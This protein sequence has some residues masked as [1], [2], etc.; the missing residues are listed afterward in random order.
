MNNPAPL[1]AIGA[2][3]GKKREDKFRGFGGWRNAA[4]MAGATLAAAAILNNWRA[5]RA[6][7]RNPPMGRF[8]L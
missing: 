4:A 2:T 7:Q 6:E 8:L 1:P 3:D 5:K